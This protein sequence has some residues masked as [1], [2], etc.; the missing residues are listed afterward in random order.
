MSLH[1]EGNSRYKV[2]G[3]FMQLFTYC[4]AYIH[5]YICKFMH[6]YSIFKYFV[7]FHFILIFLVFQPKC[8]LFD[9]E[10]NYFFFI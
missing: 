3:A 7:S 10:W 9:L 8:F 2:K 5:T 4:T 6:F 1:C